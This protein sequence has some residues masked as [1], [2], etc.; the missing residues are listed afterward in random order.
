VLSVHF[1][2]IKLDPI[3]VFKL[4]RVPVDV[5]FVLRLVIITQ[6]HLWV[7]IADVECK[8]IVLEQVLAHNLIEYGL[9]PWLS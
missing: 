7:N 8:N 9:Y 5:S 6:G 3:H 2:V 4:D 1:D